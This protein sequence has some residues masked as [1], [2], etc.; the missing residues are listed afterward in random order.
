MA[1]C[2]VQSLGRLPNTQVNHATPS[3]QHE[4]ACTGYCSSCRGTYA[5]AHAFSALRGCWASAGVQKLTGRQAVCLLSS[6]IASCKALLLQPQ[7]PMH[8]Q[9]SLFS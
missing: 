6:I 4:G 1:A 7:S 3:C 5:A 9:H 2:C 8:F